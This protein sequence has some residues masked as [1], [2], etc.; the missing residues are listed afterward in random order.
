MAA[1]A[2]KSCSVNSSTDVFILPQASAYLT[3]MCCSEATC[4][5]LQVCQGIDAY[6]PDR[7]G[8][9]PFPYLPCNDR[10]K[11][12]AA[13]NWEVSKIGATKHYSQNKGAGGR[14]RLRYNCGSTYHWFLPRSH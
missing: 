4:Q 7:P 11:A 14:Q 3:S 6:A 10:F 13:Q 5:L 1:V 8:G 9:L 2:V 12:R